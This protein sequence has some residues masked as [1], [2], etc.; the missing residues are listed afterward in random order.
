[1]ALLELSDENYYTPE[2]NKDYWSVS[3]Y[4]SFCRCEACAMAQ[5]RGE[6]K[7][8]ITKALLVG[9]YVDSYIEG[10]LDRFKQEHPE[11]FTIHAKRLRAEFRQADEII[12]R[13]ESNSYFN[14]FLS[15]E[16]QKILTAEMFSVPWKIKM[17]SFIEGK[18]I[19][20]LKVV[21]KTDSLPYWGYDL[22]GAV[23]QAVAEANGYG[24]LPFYLAVVTKEKVADM[25]IIQI[26][27]SFLDMRLKEIEENMPHLIAVKN[28]EVE[29]ARCECCDYCKLTRKT[30]VWGYSK[31][32]K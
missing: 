5:L 15:G 11:V 1:M 18:C 16:K 9:S 30:K 6:Y 7:Q 28:G 14:K 10:T 24:Y 2:A 27:Q 19:V 3:Q 8:P 20:D 12:R 4:K 26:E 21:R 17:D 31:L 22:Q 29:P 13:I 32:I 25:N 23:Y